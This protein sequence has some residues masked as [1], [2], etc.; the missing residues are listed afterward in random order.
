M[1]DFSFCGIINHRLRFRFVTGGFVMQKSRIY[2]W[3]NLRFALILL[4]VVGHFISQ[5]LSSPSFKGLWLFIYSFHMPLFIFISGCFHK[6]TNIASKVVS[7]VAIGAIYKIIVFLT[8][9]FIDQSPKFELFS[10][11]GAPWYMFAMA[12]FILLTYLLRDL[13]LKYILMIWLIVACFAGYDPKVSQF[14]SLSRIIVFYP[15]YLLGVLSNKE[16]LLGYAKNKWLKSAGIAVVVGWLVLCVVFGTKLW[17]LNGLFAGENPFNNRFYDMGALWR[18][19]CFALSA[20]L[21]YA[22]V[23]AAPTRKIPLVSTIGTRTLQIYFWHRP[24]LYIL[25]KH[26]I[27]VLLCATAG[28]KA[29][30]LLLA[31]A[32]TLVLAFKLFSFPTAQI[33]KYAQNQKTQDDSLSK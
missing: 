15:F 7:Y 24:L 27:P 22:F 28:G 19:L 26:E 4:V 32:V 14:L 21:C 10:E 1:L 31:V 2:L 11:G 12:A 17:P 8:R 13:N 20:V 18:L 30:Y 5:Y 33:I 9:E 25:Y 29:I 16:K 3:D 6:N 23:C